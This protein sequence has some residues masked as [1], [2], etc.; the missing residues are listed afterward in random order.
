[1]N[2][3]IGERGGKSDLDWFWAIFG[4]R[5]HW[6]SLI[7]NEFII[8]FQWFSMNFNQGVVQELI[9]ILIDFHEFS[10]NFVKK[11]VKNSWFSLKNG[12]SRIS[13]FG[14]W[15]ILSSNWL[16]IAEF[17]FN[18]ILSQ[19]WVDFELILSSIWFQFILIGFWS[20]SR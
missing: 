14:I 19:F 18:L 12:V 4:Q 15:S 7:L 8:N 2:P 11:M 9:R 5:F 17:E 16:K 10:L 6:F 1:M 20:I 13:Y 3:S